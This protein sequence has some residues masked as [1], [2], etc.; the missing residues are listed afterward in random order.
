MLHSGTE[1]CF[2]YKVRERYI[3]WRQVAEG[4]FKILSRCNV[5][6]VSQVNLTKILLEHVSRF[7]RTKNIFLID[8]VFNLPPLSLGIIIAN[9]S[10]PG[11]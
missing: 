2:K 9:P 4:I 3:S 10:L 6:G 11:I 1:P 5:L 7:I 8:I